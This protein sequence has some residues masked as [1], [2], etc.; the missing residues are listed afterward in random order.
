M[1]RRTNTAMWYEKQN[2]WKINVQK[3]GVRRSFY[4]SKPGRTGQREANRKADEWLDDNVISS[5]VRISKLYEEYLEEKKITTSKSNCIKLE[6]LGRNYILPHIGNLKISVLTEQKLQNIINLAYKK[7]LS[8]K[9]LM[10]IKSTITEFIKF[11]RK[12]NATT[13]YPEYLTIPKGAAYKKKKILQ[14]DDLKRLFKYDNIVMNG[15]ETYDECVPAYRFQ[16]L[17]GLRPGELLGLQ[18]S[19]IDPSDIVHISRSRNALNEITS[20]KNENA[21]RSFKLTKLSKDIIK[22]TPHRENCPYVFGDMTLDFYRYRWKKYCDYNNINYVSPYELR[23][24][25]I[26]IAKNLPQGDLKTLIGHSD[27]MDTLGVY[28]HEVDG[29]LINIAN[30]LDTIFDNILK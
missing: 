27:S 28:G 14:P 19:D 30:S 3:D 18:W 2:R 20:G 24:T 25:F 7:E 8:R 26:S 10:N 29:E 6:S 12:S 9:T 21:K 1:G 15:T 4:S 16:V 11:C 13:L 5:S 17:N 22:A 23:H